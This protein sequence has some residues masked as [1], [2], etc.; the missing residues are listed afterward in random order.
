MT[1]AL[2]PFRRVTHLLTTTTGKACDSSVLL[3]P[4]FAASRVFRHLKPYCIALCQTFCAAK[5]GCGRFFSL[6]G[7]CSDM[8]LSFY[9][10]Y[11][12]A[13]CPLAVQSL[14]FH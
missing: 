10:D 7:L 3:R 8:R 4:S 13:D 14:I 2:C 11:P 5:H 9:P 1:Y 6:S 12:L